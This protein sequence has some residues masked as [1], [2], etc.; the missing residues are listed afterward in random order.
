MMNPWADAIGWGTGIAPVRAPLHPLLSPFP[1][2][3]GGAGFPGAGWP[4]A[5]VQAPEATA[6]PPTH[7]AGIGA[8]VPIRQL[9]S[10]RAALLA[11]S[12]PQLMQPPVVAGMPQMPPFPQSFFG[13]APQ[14]GLFQPILPVAPFDPTPLKERMQPNP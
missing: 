8:Y 11:P 7:P 5:P 9:P 12:S 2:A 13:G 6:L 1:V 4:S 14:S 3:P 10:G